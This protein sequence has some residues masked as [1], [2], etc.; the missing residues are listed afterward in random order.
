[1]RTGIEVKRCGFFLQ[2]D[3]TRID[4]SASIDLEQRPIISNDRELI[5]PRLLDQQF[6]RL[7]HTERR[8]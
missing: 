3:I 5:L 8:R 1:M 2:Q 6:A 7:L 4:D